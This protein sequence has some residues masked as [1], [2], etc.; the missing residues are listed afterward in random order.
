MSA[1][2]AH[3]LYR[4]AS[5]ATNYGAQKC[6][7]LGVQ[8]YVQT[9]ALTE[10]FACADSENVKG[11]AERQRFFAPRNCFESATLACRGP[12]ARR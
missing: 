7:D 6:T 4:W 1:K 12:S 11:S 8:G 5:K 9:L 10:V 3:S 2:C